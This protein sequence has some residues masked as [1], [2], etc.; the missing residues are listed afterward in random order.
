[1]TGQA[2]PSCGCGRR[3]RS[4]ETTCGDDRC[5][6]QAMAQLRQRPTVRT[7]PPPPPFPSRHVQVGGLQV[8][9]TDPSRPHVPHEI[10]CAACKSHQ[11]VLPDCQKNRWG[12]CHNVLCGIA[13]DFANGD[14]LGHIAGKLMGLYVVSSHGRVSLELSKAQLR[15]CWSLPLPS[16]A[17][18]PTRE[19]IARVFH[20]GL[21]IIDERLEIL[22]SLV[23][24]LYVV[25]C[26]GR[27][28]LEAMLDYDEHWK[29]FDEG[30]ASARRSS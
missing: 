19:D 17:R 10:P 28:T 13:R 2:Q 30:L 1:M 14:G 5:V 22:A 26:R 3:A 6:A 7:T 12:H 20:D 9:L 29:T 16:G 24:A 8:E 18:A 21:L 4:G 25:T 23:G 27:T 11:H 15:E